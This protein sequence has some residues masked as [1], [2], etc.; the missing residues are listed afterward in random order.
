LSSGAFVLRRVWA[1]L[2]YETGWLRK[3]RYA[4]AACFVLGLLAISLA[5]N[6]LSG[7]I[8]EA[9][10]YKAQVANPPMTPAFSPEQE[11]G[12]QQVLF[13][14]KR[15]EKAANPKSY[16]VELLS[17]SAQQYRLQVNGVEISE[18][19]EESESESLWKPRLFRL[20]LTG[21]G[22][23]LQMWLEQLERLPIPIAMTGLQVGAKN[24]SSPTTQDGAKNF[25]PLQIVLECKVWLPEIS[26]RTVEGDNP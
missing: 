3:L 22:T 25:S 26:G 6:K 1:R 4:A 18:Q 2:S 21:K 15:F 19:N 17:V 14:V 8:S 24:L 12:Q 5:I 9:D 23:D 10:A 13:I 7:I 16:A 11:A 20:R